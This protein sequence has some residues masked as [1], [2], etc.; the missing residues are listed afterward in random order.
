MAKKESSFKNMVL[1]LLVITLI[2]STALGYVFELTKAPIA[3]SKLLKKLEAIKQV[4]PGFNNDPNAEV[5]KMIV[6]GTNDSLEIYPAKQDS[7][8]QAY[9]IKTFTN[10]GFS[11]MIALMVGFDLEGNIINISVLEHA[12]TPGLGDKMSKT[13][14]E[15]S[16]QYNGKNPG[17]N[18]L[19]VKQDGGEI[20]AITASTI[21]SRAFSDA[22]NRA[23]QTIK[24]ILIPSKS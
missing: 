14:S 24:P 21:S 13:K 19:N 18:N 10:K 6:P 5:F 23:Y 8:I 12:E 22:V 1:T 17:V 20:D 11:G 4:T 16:V 15:W 3:Q 7:I 2:A 9:A